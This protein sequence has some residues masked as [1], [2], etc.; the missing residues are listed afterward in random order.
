VNKDFH[1]Y[2]YLLTCGFLRCFH[3]CM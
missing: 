3:V 1:S 2:S